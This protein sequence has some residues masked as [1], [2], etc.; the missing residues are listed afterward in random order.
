VDNLERAL[1]AADTENPLVQGIKLTQRD[2][3][4]ALNNHGVEAIDPVGEPFD[5]TWHQAL[6]TKPSQDHEAGIVLVT[7]RKGYRLDDQLIRP[8]LVIVS[9]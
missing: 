6:T 4:M 7:E 1:E 2:L 5:P 9:E 8:A 3:Y